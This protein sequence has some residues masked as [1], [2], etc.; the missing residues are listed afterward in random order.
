MEQDISK[1]RWFSNA[2][3]ISIIVF[4][5]IA[6]FTIAMIYARFTLMEKEI[7]VL[8]KRIEYVNDRLTRKIN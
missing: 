1:K 7:D 3:V 8:R 4:A 5:V 6:T 2:Q